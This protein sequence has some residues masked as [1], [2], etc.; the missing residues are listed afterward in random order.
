MSSHAV[1]FAFPVWAFVVAAV[2]AIALISSAQNRRR[3][4]REYRRYDVKVCTQ[5]GANLPVHAGFCS[6]CGRRLER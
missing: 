4:E 6:E 1:M 2:V 3:R 5:C